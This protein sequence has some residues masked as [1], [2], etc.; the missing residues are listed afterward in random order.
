MAE[1]VDVRRDD[2]EAPARPQDPPAFGEKGDRFLHVLEHVAGGDRVEGAV[3]IADG[4]ELADVDRDAVLFAP[5][6][7]PP[8]RTRYRARSSRGLHR[9]G[10]GAAAAADVEQRARG[11]SSR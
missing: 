9:R 2:H 1:A 11:R 7:P 6:A 4:G 10:V 5:A 3:G 8:D